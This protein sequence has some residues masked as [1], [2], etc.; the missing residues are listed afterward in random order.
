MYQKKAIS[1]MLLMGV[2]GLAA[3]GLFS[4]AKAVPPTNYIV[5]AT[6]A[7]PV[8]MDPMY[9]W[10]SASLDVAEQVVQTLYW[11]NV[12]EANTPIEPLLAAALPSISANGTQYNITLRQGVLFH[13]GTPFNAA[14]ANATFERLAFF[15]DPNCPAVGGQTDTAS[16]YQWANGTNFIKD[17][18][19]LNTYEIQVNLNVPYGP[20]LSLLTFNSLSMLSP[21]ALSLMNCTQEYLQ[22]G[23]QASPYGSGN[24]PY[25]SENMTGTGPYTFGGYSYSNSKV[26]FTAFANYWGQMAHV[27]YL[28]F[29]I[30]TNGQTLDTAMLAKQD[31]ISEATL[32]GDIA[33][34]NTT[35]GLT[36]DEGPQT[37]TIE[38]L[39][40]N[41][42][43]INQSCREALA[44][45][46]DYNYY[47][48]T[49]RLG[50]AS[51]LHGVI[52]AGMVFYDNSLPYAT[53]N[54]TRARIAMIDTSAGLQAIKNTAHLLTNNSFW[55][56]LAG[57]VSTGYAG[58]NGPLAR[59]N[60]T[61]NTDNLVRADTGTLLKT[62]AA[63]V[64]IVID[65]AGTT[66]GNF[67]NLLTHHPLQMGIFD[68]GWAPDFNDPDDYIGPLLCPSYSN[69]AVLGGTTSSNRLGT[70]D[71]II[72][73]YANAARASAVPA[74]RQAAYTA[75]SLYIQNVSFPY[76]WLAQ[77]V[78]RVLH[79][80]NLLGFPNNA[81]NQ[82]FFS[83][84]YYS[85]STAPGPTTPGFDMTVMCIAGAGVLV[86]I[87]LV[88]RKNFMS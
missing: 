52:P 73:G 63:F 83:Y 87:V 11:Y 51:A 29:D 68:L 33:T 13:D 79:L 45:C 17:T 64:G 8:Y 28:V 43:V 3:A 58:F 41:D 16:L 37:L 20:F 71:P 10:D 5:Y 2:A 75:L 74:V 69:G 25:A 61:Y 50:L 65:L 44:Y 81:F 55:L 53:L 15:I 36:L 72:N 47:L 82:V 46:F 62:N 57:G 80:S 60:F 88:K 35:A 7:G 24:S 84:C 49:I 66:W 26:S 77:G 42:Q 23:N 67:I 4:T 31:S 86:S 48:N 9:I 39:S 34:A 38:Y 14:A 18:K 27:H 56:D 32:P 12:T 6:E 22:F 76:I 78:S 40:M 54:I 1:L 59:Y 19:I 30:F 21:T 70:G 85:S